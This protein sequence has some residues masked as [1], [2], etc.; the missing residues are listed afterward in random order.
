MPWSQKGH[1]SIQRIV[2]ALFCVLK[3]S[4]RQHCWGYPSGQFCSYSALQIQLQQGHALVPSTLNHQ[5]KMLFL[6][7]SDSNCFWCCNHLLL[8]SLSSSSKNKF[9]RPHISHGKDKQEKH[10]LFSALHFHITKK[11]KHS[12][13]LL[14]SHVRKSIQDIQVKPNQHARIYLFIKSVDGWL[15]HP[16]IWASLESY[17]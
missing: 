10:T 9:D 2:R 15:T 8:L 7:C 17:Q 5:P 3:T 1:A 13:L 14:T 11:H 6:S 4:T 16:H 12:F